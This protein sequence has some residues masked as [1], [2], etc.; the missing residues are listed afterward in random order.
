LLLALGAIFGSIGGWIA[1]TAAHRGLANEATAGV[2][3]GLASLDR[4]DLAAIA[5]FI[6]CVLIGIAAAW[7]MTEF[8]TQ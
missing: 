4:A 8:F 7:A 6:V 1:A 5:V 3:A 2:M